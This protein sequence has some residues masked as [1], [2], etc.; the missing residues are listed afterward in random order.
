MAN[1]KRD[2]HRNKR[3]VVT[4]FVHVVSLYC[5]GGYHDIPFET[6]TASVVLGVDNEKRMLEC[7]E[8]FHPNAKTL[9]M[10]LS[11]S[12]VPDVLG[13]IRGCVPS[14]ARLHLN[15][16]LPCNYSSG[17]SGRRRHHITTEHVLILFDIVEALKHEFSLTWFSENIPA[18]TYVT[19]MRLLFPS[20]QHVVV[21]SSR[22]SYEKRKRAYFASGPP[23]DL[24]ELVRLTGGG[25]VQEC[26]SLRPNEYQMKSGSTKY[27]A[28]EKSWRDVTGPA[29]TLT[30][31]GLYL[32]RVDGTLHPWLVPGPALARL[33]CLR[34]PPANLP[35]VAQRQAVSRAVTGA[36]SRVVARQVCGT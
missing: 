28:H 21:C 11:V 31:N 17:T 1:E 24:N 22:F 15:A 7:F 3:R 12:A 18:A 4:A 27:L 36:V 23:M 16:C 8:Q 30:T 9:N 35:V 5:G 32:R 26:F 6:A 20:A 33:R 25:T 29:P 14:N 10:T 2:E 13:A 19:P 34:A